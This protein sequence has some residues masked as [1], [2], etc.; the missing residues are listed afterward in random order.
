MAS[1]I[2]LTP[3]GKLHCRNIRPYDTTTTIC[4]RGIPTDATEP[5][6]GEKVDRC[7][8]CCGVLNESPSFRIING[9][10]GK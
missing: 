6:R 2:R 1:W 8:V 4:G 9:G 3:H 5:G 7:K 10:K